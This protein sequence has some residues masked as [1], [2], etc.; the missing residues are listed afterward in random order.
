[1]LK[2]KSIQSYDVWV[3]FT[4]AIVNG[5]MSGLGDCTEQELNSLNGFI[6]DHKSSIVDVVGES[7][8]DFCDIAGE[9]SDC[10]RVDVIALEER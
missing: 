4:S 6:A 3:G 5:D 8:H 9:W 7:Y 10:I 1:M 2:T